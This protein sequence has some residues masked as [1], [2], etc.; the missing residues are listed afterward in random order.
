VTARLSLITGPAGSGKT[1]R[2]LA[3]YRAALREGPPGTGL[4]LTPTWRSA[5]AARAAL[6]SDMPDGCLAP[7]VMTFAKFAEAVLQVAPAVIRPLSGLMK[8]QLVRQIL[9]AQHRAGRLEHFA[10][11]ADTSGLVDQVG[12]LIGELKRL[13]IWPAEFLRACEAR[14][15]RPKDRELFELYDA[16]QQQLLEHNLYDAEGRFWSARELLKRGQRRP[17]ERLRLVV[18]DGFTDFTRTQHEILELL[19]G[20]V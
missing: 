3:V 7:G 13:E 11:I 4:W 8:R 18:A 15:L 17:F 2:V 16:Y 19:A 14:G 12:D 10:P 6:L 5:A 20:R 9:A 1:E